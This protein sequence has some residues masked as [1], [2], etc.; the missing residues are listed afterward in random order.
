MRTVETER[1]ARTGRLVE[2]KAGAPMRKFWLVTIIIVLLAA[3]CGSSDSDVA[4][5]SSST[6]D[7]SNNEDDGGGADPTDSNDDGEDAAD[8]DDGG[9]GGEDSGDDDPDFSGSGSGDFCDTAREF[10][11]NDPL[12]GLSI[13]D[14][15]E[16]FDAADELWDEVLPQVPDEIRADVETIISGVDEMRAIGEEYDYQFFNA[17]ASEAF[18]AIDTAPMDAASQRFD[19]YLEDVCG[20][21]SF[22][23][24]SDTG[25]GGS[26]TDIDLGDLT[27]DQLTSSAAF[28]A[29]IFGIDMET[30]ECLVTELGDIGSPGGIDPTQ[31]D[32]PVC[33]TTLNEV[34]SGAP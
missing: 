28:I 21:D 5:D 17:A 19:A 11:E 32:I 25:A 31:L 9:D 27:G 14:G 12:E 30:A 16:F 1:R 10:E 4:A 33:G 23:S 20:I 26:D 15:E 18:E 13:T 29:D 3:A 6:S 7:V 22:A 24:G 2:Q 34:L 8:G